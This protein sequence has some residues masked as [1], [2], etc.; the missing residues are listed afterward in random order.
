MT[1]KKMETQTPIQT[2]NPVIITPPPPEVPL[3]SKEGPSEV[4]PHHHITSWVA[5]V[6]IATIA[7]TTGYLLWAKSQEAW[8]FDFD[9]PWSEVKRIGSQ[10]ETAG[11]NIC[12]NEAYGFEV[13]YPPNWK[14]WRVGAP[15]ASVSSCEVGL[16]TAGFSPNLLEL[17]LETI[18]QINVDVDSETVK[19]IEDYR[20]KH[21]E[22][23]YFNEITRESTIDGQKLY[24]F[25]ER[26]AITFY[27]GKMFRFSMI[28][29]IDESTLNLFF[30]TFKFIKQTPKVN[31]SNWNE[32]Y[33]EDQ[34][35]IRYPT[36]FRFIDADD[37]GT[38]HN[39][40]FPNDGIVMGTILFPDQKGTNLSSASISMARYDGYLTA[41]DCKLYRNVDK[42]SK[43]T[44]TETVEY[45]F[46]KATITGAAAGTK[47]TQYIYRLYNSNCFEISLDIRVGNIA[48]Y[49]TGTV[50]EVD[51]DT[52]LDQFKSILST[53]GII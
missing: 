36:D 27:D 22:F 26:L 10:S 48:N 40:F 42:I 49:E 39:N 38:Y 24:W 34:F 41:E 30:S 21:P 50:N 18:Q 17:S 20:A 8:P 46:Y 44:E 2:Q 35:E 4:K 3:L 1:D 52:I 9:G 43:M 11:W 12:K 15:E 29:N 32:Y 47:V 23:F 31:A 5:L 33:Y 7:A 28:Q 6:I 19:T 14:V 13:K 37:S 25:G 45:E 16:R 51:E 53:V